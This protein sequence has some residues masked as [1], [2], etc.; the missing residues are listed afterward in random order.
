[1]FTCV[2]VSFSSRGARDCD[3]PPN[4]T[5][6]LHSHFLTRVCSFVRVARRKV[7]SV[8]KSRKTII[9][10]SS[11]HSCSRVG[12]QVFRFACKS[13]ILFV[14][15]GV[16]V[17]VRSYHTAEFETPIDTF[18]R[19]ASQ[20]PRFSQVLYRVAPDKTRCARSGKQVDAGCRVHVC[21]DGWVYLFDFSS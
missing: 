11:R 1:M 2:G 21:L 13:Q 16:C 10:V 19:H 20:L 8:Q 3:H 6:P 17:R 18:D 4:N 15:R 9:F 5:F 14:V 12:G 7:D